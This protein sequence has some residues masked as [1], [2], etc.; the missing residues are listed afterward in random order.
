MMML[1]ASCVPTTGGGVK[2]VWTDGREKAVERNWQQQL[3]TINTYFNI[4]CTATDGDG[5]PAYIIL[6]GCSRLYSI[7]KTK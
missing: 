4:T 3:T 2:S 1:T 5:R 7:L 6:N